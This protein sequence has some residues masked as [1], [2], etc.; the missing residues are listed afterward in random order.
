MLLVLLVSITVLVVWMPAVAA[1]QPLPLLL[2]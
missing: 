1:V 2:L